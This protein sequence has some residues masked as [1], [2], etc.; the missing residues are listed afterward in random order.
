MLT[1]RDRTARQMMCASV[2]LAS[3]LLLCQ[4]MAGGE[5][6]SELVRAKVAEA[7]GKLQEAGRKSPDL[8]KG[9][10]RNLDRSEVELNGLCYVLS[11]CLYHLFP[12]A[13]TPC[14]ISWDDGTTHWFLRYGDG[15]ILDA[16]G[17]GGKAWCTE[18]EYGRARR[19][20]FLTK[21][22]SKRARTLLERAGLALP[23]AVPSTNREKP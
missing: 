23:D 8:I 19:A 1:E 15:S 16:V 3:L 12:G 6:E 20:A 7:L 21:S 18:E 4:P 5:M 10:Y 9:K 14:R 2:V 17:P 11:E 13:F 22:P